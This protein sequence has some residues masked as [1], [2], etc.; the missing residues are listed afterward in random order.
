MN[1][2]IFIYKILVN[3]KITFNDYMDY[4]DC[5]MDYMHM[6]YNIDCNMDCLDYIDCMD[7][8]MDCNMDCNMDYNM[9]YNT[10]YNMN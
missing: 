1:H 9:D 8:N 10:D 4:T 5:N 2:K 3:F 6:D 7:Y